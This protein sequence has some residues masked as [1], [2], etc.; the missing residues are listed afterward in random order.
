M[1]HGLKA[2]RVKPL[3][4]M[5]ILMFLKASL[6]MVERVSLLKGWGYIA[7]TISSLRDLDSISEMYVLTK[8]TED[9][10]TH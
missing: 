2:V 1:R 9:E 4:G 8:T 5:T 6:Q 7:I 3:N 10:F